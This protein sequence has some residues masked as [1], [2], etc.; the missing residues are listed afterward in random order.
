MKEIRVVIDGTEV[1]GREGMTIL[2]AAEQIGIGIP[3]LCHTKELTPVG[4]CR[5]CVVEVEGSGRLVGSCHTPIEEGMAIH[6]C[7]PRVLEARKAIIELLLAGHTGP[8]VTD[9][10]AEHCELH[11]IAAELESG[12]PRFRVRKP[13][14][15][16][17]EELSPYVRRDMSKCILCHRCIRACKEI[18]QQSIYSMAYRAF[19]S[20]VVVDFDEPLNK[21]VCK[22]CGICIDYCP[23][24]ALTWPDG[25][26]KEKVVQIDKDKIQKQLPLEERQREKLLVMLEDVQGKAGYVSQESMT[27]MAQTLGLTLSEVYGVATFYAFISVKPK[28]KNVI[29]ICKSLPCYMKNAPMIIESIEKEI[30]IKP[31]ETTPDGKFSFELTNCIGFCDQAPAM[32]VNDDVYGNLSPAKISEILA[33]YK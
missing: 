2:E 25:V 18:V 5:I 29:R 15:Y 17:V 16:P 32:L 30:G 27:D 23:T 22:E 4:S 26:K 1:S 31:G 6:T 24:N 14:F 8:C 19:N 28:G 10:G 13:R 20:K 9:E 21:E 12:P 3:T 7:S 11:K 33:S